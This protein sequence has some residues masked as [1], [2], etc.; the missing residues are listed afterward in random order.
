[1]ARVVGLDV[2][3]VEFADVVQPLAAPAG[4]DSGPAPAAGAQRFERILAVGGNAGVDGGLSGFRQGRSLPLMR[5][6]VPERRPGSTRRGRWAVSGCAG[7]ARRV[8]RRWWCR[9]GAARGASPGGGCTR[10]GGTGTA[11]RS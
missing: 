2:L 8:R 1:M 3:L 10:R 7:P 11:A 9:R 6:V 5:W 4:E